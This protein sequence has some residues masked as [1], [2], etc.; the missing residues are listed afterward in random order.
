MAGISPTARDWWFCLI[1]IK[2][3]S[4]NLSLPARKQR[5]LLA[6]DHNNKNLNK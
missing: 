6:R 4:T 2:Q 5:S 3:N 1:K